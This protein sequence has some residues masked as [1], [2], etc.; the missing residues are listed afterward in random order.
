MPLDVTWKGLSTRMHLQNRRLGIGLALLLVSCVAAQRA[1]AQEISVTLLGTGSPT[2]AIDRF[3]PSTL[4]QAGTQTLLFDLGRGAHQRLAQ[5]GVTAGQ[6]DAIFLTHLHSDHIVGIPDLW[7]TGWLITA[8]ARPWEIFGPTGTG[9]MMAALKQAFAIDLRVRVEENAGQLSAEG[10]VINARDIE[11]G[12]VYE[13]DGVRVTA[14]RVDH[15]AIAP[16]YGYRIDYRGRS[17]VLS[18]DTQLSP[19]LIKASAGTGLLV[20][21]VYQASDAVLKQNPRTAVVKT[22]R[23][24]GAEAGAVFQQVRPKLAVYSHIVLRGVDLAELI[25]RTRTAYSGP[26]VVGEDLMRFVVG[27]DV[28]VYRP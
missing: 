19:D 2:P 27:D 5:A 9:Q 16:A 11:P 18:G 8:R 3:G 14:V 24:D 10:A 1:S 17:V 23:V 26:L 7:L 13:R 12:V 22:F 15:R 4:V 6:V 28:T 20:H 25:R 21:E